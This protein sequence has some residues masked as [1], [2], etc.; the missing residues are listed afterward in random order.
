MKVSVCIPTY[1]SA[2][3]LAE[4]IQS[5]LA[6][7]DVDFE[8]VISDNASDDS[9]WDIINSFSDPRIRASRCAKNEGMAANFNRVLQQAHGEY[10]KVLCSNDV[11]DPNAKSKGR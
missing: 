2:A 3:Y 7:R 6:Q 4:C 11:L 1:N 10:V 9:T 8:I 5:V